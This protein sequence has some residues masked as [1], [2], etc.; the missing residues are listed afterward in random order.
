V[1]AVCAAEVG[2]DKSSAQWFNAVS[3]FRPDNFVR[4]LGGAVTG[5]A[6]GK[7]RFVEGYEVLDGEG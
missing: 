5:K 7:R 4:K 2:K 3:P 6:E 1:I